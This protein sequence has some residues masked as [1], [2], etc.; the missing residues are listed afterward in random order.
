MSSAMAQSDDHRRQ[1]V[2]GKL[3]QLTPDP[4][5]T[6]NVS[7]SLEQLR[8]RDRARRPWRV[9]TA[10]A[11]TATIL[12]A[13]PNPTLRAFA[14]KCG[15]FVARVTGFNHSRPSIADLTLKGFDGQAVRLSASRGN[16]VVLTIWPPTCA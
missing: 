7:R 11:V 5:W 2:D 4:V 12:F 1:W 6:P 16:V 10:V 15:V 13:I 14:H 3:A 8:C 9:W